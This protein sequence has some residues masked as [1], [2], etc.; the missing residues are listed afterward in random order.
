MSIWTSIRLAL[1]LLAAAMAFF[2][3]LG[4]EATPPIAWPHLIWM[5]LA[6]PV[7]L[8]FVVGMQVRNPRSASVWRHPSWA[9]NPFSLR[10]PLQFF[11]FAG[12]VFIANGIG[13]IARLAFARAPL[14]VDAMLSLVMGLGVLTGV[15]LCVVVF[16]SKMTRRASA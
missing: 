11:H 9:L 15:A 14:Q 3:P 2:V 16:R 6:C 5:Y 8:L 4:P 12:F 1:V 13:A 7:L 10:E